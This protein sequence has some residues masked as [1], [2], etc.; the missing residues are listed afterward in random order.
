MMTMMK[1]IN[2]NVLIDFMNTVK[3]KMELKIKNNSKLA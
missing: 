2:L 1:M 3:N